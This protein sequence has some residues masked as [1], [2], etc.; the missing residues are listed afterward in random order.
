MTQVLFSNAL[1]S[2]QVNGYNVRVVIRRYFNLGDDFS[3]AGVLFLNDL[4]LL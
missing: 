4:C 3:D 2:L 1:C